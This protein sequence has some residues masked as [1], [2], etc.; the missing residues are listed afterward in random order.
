MKK[1]L[2]LFLALLLCVPALAEERPVIP[3]EIV[4]ERAQNHIQVG[5]NEAITKTMAEMPVQP[6]SYQ[7]R[8]EVVRMSDGSFRW[9]VTVFD[10]TTLSNGWCVEID[11]ASGAV[12]ASYTTYDGFFLDVLDKWI[13]AMGKSKDLWRMEDKALFD[14][15]YA[16]QPVYGIPKEGDMSADD[17]LERATIAVGPYFLDDEVSGYLASFGYL[18]GGEGYNG[19]WEVCLSKDGVVNYRVNLDAVTGEI[20]YIE[21]DEAG[22]G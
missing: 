18:M 16:L 9:I 17:A 6:A 20:Y 12:A 8:A 1:I 11:A 2:M 13:T 10:L 7:T 19:V 14:A 3:V 22:N 21:P 5:L 15:L 4:E